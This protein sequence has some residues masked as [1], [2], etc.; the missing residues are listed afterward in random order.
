MANWKASG[1]NPFSLE[2]NNMT[3]IKF[4]D[5]DVAFKG[6]AENWIVL[7]LA[8]QLYGKIIEKFLFS[9]RKKKDFLRWTRKSEQEV[10][11]SYRVWE[12]VD[13]DPLDGKP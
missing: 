4:Y 8:S 2:V 3:T 13:C 5:I 6:K 7:W 10:S 1:R 12:E 11:R 9:K